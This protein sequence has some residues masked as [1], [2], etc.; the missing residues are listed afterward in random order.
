MSADW[1]PTVQLAITTVGAIGVAWITVQQIRARARLAD[2]TARM[3]RAAHRTESAANT[4]ET[5]IGEM[6]KMTE[7]AFNIQIHPKK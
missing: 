6:T 7:T 5:Q 2:A 3:E 4:V 1:I